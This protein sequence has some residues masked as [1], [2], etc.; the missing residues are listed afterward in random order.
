[1]RVPMPGTEAGQLV[2]V[3]KLRNWSGAKGGSVNNVSHF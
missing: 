3:K 1:M 2:V